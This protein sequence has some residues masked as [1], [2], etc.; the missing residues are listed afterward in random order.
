MAAGVVLVVNGA[1]VV[2]L[3]WPTNAAAPR[4]LATY[5]VLSANVHVG[6]RDMTPLV[7]LLRRRRPDVVFL[8]EVQ[9]AALAQLEDLDDLYPYRILRPRSDAFGYALF[10]RRPITS[11]QTE[12]FTNVGP[13]TLAATIDFDGR[14]VVLIG[15]HPPPP[16]SSLLAQQRDRQLGAIGK[17]AA[18]RKGPLIL[19][20]DLNTTSWSPIFQ[21]LLSESGL[22]DSRAGFGPQPSWPNLPWACRIPI[23]HILVSREV[24]TVSREVGPD[25]GSDHLPVFATL[26]F[27]D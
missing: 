27:D 15:T 18:S 2:P 24:R 9:Q 19:L 7:Q 1:A 16:V 25:V 26:L 3:Y 21:D 11:Q 23:D 5:S 22:R 13:Q 20:G 8:V 14:D 4:S 10:S 17:L 12:P 6:N